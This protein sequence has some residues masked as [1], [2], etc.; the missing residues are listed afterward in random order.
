MGELMRHYWL[1]ALLSSE[2]PGPDS[3]PVRV[4]AAGREAHRLPRHQRQ[5]RP[6]A[7][8]LSPPRSQPVLRPQRRVRHALRLPRLE[9]RRRR[10]LR[11]H[12][13]R[14]RRVRLQTQGQSDGLPDARSAAASS[15]PISAR[16]RRRRRCRT[17]KPTC[18]PT[19]PGRSAQ[20]SASATGCRRS[21]ATSTPVTSASCTS[22]PM[23]ADDSGA[24]HLRLLH[25][26]GP[27]AALRG[28]RHR[29]RRHVRRLSSGGGR[30]G[31]LAHRAISC[32]RATR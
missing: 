12:A 26:E 25:A 11:R 1:P 4:R 7:T 8:R 22:A 29:L 28:G 14:A 9:V 3:D 17:S 18:C 5:R 19:A 32:S 10:Q 23:S 13:Q 24:R 21:R 2:L 27:R 6:D 20:S 15:G 30:H 16:A 31:L